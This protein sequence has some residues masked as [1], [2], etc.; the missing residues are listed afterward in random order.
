VE[1]GV[2]AGILSKEL[3][4]VVEFVNEGEEDVECTDI[5]IPR[6]HTIIWYIFAMMCGIAIA[7]AKAPHTHLAYLK[8]LKVPFRYRWVMLIAMKLPMWTR[9]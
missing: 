8:Y 6:A 2:L 3:M 4:P 5:H 1:V 9:T 7:Y